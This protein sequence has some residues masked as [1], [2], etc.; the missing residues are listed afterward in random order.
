MTRGAAV[1]VGVGVGTGR[2][3]S[4]TWEAEVPRTR[5]FP[6]ANISLAGGNL[7]GGPPGQALGEELRQR[8]VP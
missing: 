6:W 1:L 4:A 7:T 2:A 8:P 5:L 3:M